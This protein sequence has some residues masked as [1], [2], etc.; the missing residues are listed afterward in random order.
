MKHVAYLVDGKVRWVDRIAPF[1]FAGGKPLNTL[2]LQNGKHVLE[3]RAYGAKSWT[4]HRFTVR[5]ATRRSRSR[6]SG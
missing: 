4:R 2:G 6:P 5:V 1:A 3:V